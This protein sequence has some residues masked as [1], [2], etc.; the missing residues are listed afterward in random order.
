MKMKMKIGKAKL[1][2]GGK[3]FDVENVEV[4]M[5]SDQKPYGGIRRM[6]KWYFMRVVVG[7]VARFWP[8]SSYYYS[9]N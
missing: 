7:F 9:E 3:G 4:E 1:Y 2:I 6:R 8:W 5:N